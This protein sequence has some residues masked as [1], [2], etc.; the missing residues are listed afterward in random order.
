M[1]GS[2]PKNSKC[3]SPSSR[4]WSCCQDRCALGW[5]HDDDQLHY[6]SQGGARGHSLHQRYLSSMREVRY[7]CRQALYLSSRREGRDLCRQAQ[8]L[9]SRRDDGGFCLLVDHWDSKLEGCGLHL[10]LP[11]LTVWLEGRGHRLE[12]R[13]KITED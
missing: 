8:Y 6:Q 4:A 13:M 3:F 10:P 12:Q 7:L 1:K 2:G 9:S 11:H 5:R